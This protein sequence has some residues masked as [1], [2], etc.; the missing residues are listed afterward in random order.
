MSSFVLSALRPLAAVAL[1]AG[2]A[3]AQAPL[4]VPMPFGIFPTDVSTAGGQVVVV[5]YSTVTGQAVRWTLAGG[6]VHIGS[7]SGF[8]PTSGGAATVRISRDGT[9]IVGELEVAGITSA[10]VWAGGTTWNTI[11]GIGGTSGGISTHSRAINSNGTV[12]AGLGWAAGG[13]GHPYKWTQGSGTIDLQPFFSSPSASAF[14]INGDG[15]I[16]VGW[17][18]IGGPW[19][20]A[21]WVGT[22]KTLFTY[23]DPSNVVHNVGEAYAINAAGTIVVGRRIW[24]LGAEAWRWDA[25]AGN[26]VVTPL[27]N[28]P[29]VG[30]S[31]IA[32]DLT[33]DGT[34]IVGTNGLPFIGGIQAVIW[35]NN[36]PQRLY[37]YLQ[38]L[39]ANVSGFTDLG[40]PDAISP[41]GGVIV[42]SGLGTTALTGWVVIFPEFLPN[43]TPACAGD[44]SGTICPCA[45]NSSS[46]SG[47]GCLNSLALGG[48]LRGT[49]ISSVSN[50]TLALTS[51]QVPNGP[52]LYFQ[53]DGLFAA[54]Q[55]I[56][57]G[58]GLLCAGGGIIRLGVKFASGNTSTW[59]T[60]GDPLISVQGGVSAGAT[61]HYQ[62]WYRDADT[63]F[64]TPSFFN[65][66]NALSVDWTN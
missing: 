37:T 20:G 42:G 27:A 59:G 13:T 44:G 48:T 50:D 66:T 23:V 43:G 11:P 34:L 17:E 56:T 12:L 38:G 5:G 14:G 62:T 28:L 21:R 55:G 58:D 2:V 45:N 53:G 26:G 41:E 29:G 64:C 22:T 25:G 40:Y 3:G 19:Y 60:L 46:G 61:R 8:N 36:V 32:T 6:D 31:G 7:T 65:L 15:T 24:N 39:G 1:T 35:I 63:G 18:S 33:D 16:V 54:G 57:F 49:G 47:A 4:L 9:T 30:A 52:A 10:A 51:T